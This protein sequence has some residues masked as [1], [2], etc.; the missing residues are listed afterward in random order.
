MTNSPVLRGLSFAVSRQKSK[1]D[2]P[3]PIPSGTGAVSDLKYAVGY[4][5]PDQFDLISAAVGDHVQT[6]FGKGRIVKYRHAEGIF[7][8]LLRPWGE[9]DT[10]D[11]EGDTP[12]DQKLPLKNP[13]TTGLG[14]FWSNYRPSRP[15]LYCTA[16]SFQRL[17]KVQKNRCTIM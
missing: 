6:P 15:L 2:P 12:K 4:F 1:D 5:Q 14:S 7:E 8:I 11:I 16:S 13:A 17:E 3:T 10:N 9:K